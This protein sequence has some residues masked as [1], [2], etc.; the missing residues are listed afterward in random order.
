[1]LAPRAGSVAHVML[2]VPTPCPAV[3]QPL[4]QLGDFQVTRAVL[5]YRLVRIIS[6]LRRF[7]TGTPV[8]GRTR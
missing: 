7:A 3:T 4:S 1:M 8:V 6:L 2:A 5:R